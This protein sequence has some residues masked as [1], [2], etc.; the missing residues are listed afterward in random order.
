MRRELGLSDSMMPHFSRWLGVPRCGF[1]PRAAIAVLIALCAVGPQIAAAADWVEQKFDRQIRPILEDYCYNCH[2]NG[3]KKGGVNLD[4]LT[5]DQ[6]RLRD[7]DLWWR[8]LKNVRA[9]I[10]PPAG[11]PRPADQEQRRLEDWIKY[12]A[13][14]IDPQEPRPRPRHR[15]PAQPGR[16]PQ[17][18]PRPDGRRLRHHVRVSRRTTPGTGSTTSATS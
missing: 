4:G 6:A 14:G 5:T 10:M 9:G 11:K 13:F 16:V 3:V 15:P 17:H 2:G 1:G 18:D 8:V 7:H 12:G